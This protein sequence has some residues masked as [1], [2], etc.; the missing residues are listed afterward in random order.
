MKKAVF[1]VLMLSASF[2]V[3]SVEQIQIVT[4]NLKP[5]NYLEG[6]EVKGSST[7]IVRKLLQESGLTGSIQVYP[8]ARSYA[9]ALRQ[10]NTLIYTINRTPERE[11]KFKWIGLTASKKYNS[12]LYKLKSNHHIQAT[13]LE[14]AK[15]Y[16]VGVNIGDVNHELLKSEGFEYISAVSQRSQ[17]IKMLMRNRIDLIVGSYPILWEEFKRLGESVDRIEVLLPFRVSQPFIAMSKQTPDALVN[18]LRSAY[19]RLVLRG[20]IPDF[21]SPDV[22]QIV[23]QAQ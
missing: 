5:L 1:M 11:S 13:N 19:Q 18:K 2:S 4:E 8:W 3:F 12:S 21:E 14:G 7:Q 15:A 20:D 9:M 17:S 10:K 22:E 6:N 16:T 23:L